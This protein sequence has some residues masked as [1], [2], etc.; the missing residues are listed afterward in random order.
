M[1][2][3]PGILLSGGHHPN[4]EGTSVEVYV[5]STGHSCSLPS[6]PD[7]RWGHSMDSLLICGGYDSASTASSCLSF[8]SG[9][10]VFSHTLEEGRADH[11]SWQREQ[12]I[13]LMGGYVPYTSEIVHM[14]GEQGEQSF[15]MEYDSKY[16]LTTGID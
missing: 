16:V 3:I 14:G 10:W 5:P 2:N 13:L 11:T 4:V 7:D 6:L 1:L 8:S 9:Q 15:A 12:D